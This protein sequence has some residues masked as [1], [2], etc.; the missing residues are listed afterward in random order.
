[1]ETPLKND[2]K[3]NSHRSNHSNH[4]PHLNDSKS[5][6]DKKKIV[7]VTGSSGREELMVKVSQELARRH[8]SKGYFLSLAPGTVASF[9]TSKG[10]D[11]DNVFQLAPLST[12][13]ENPDVDYVRKSE[14]RY[15]F[16]V[17]DIWQLTALRNKS[18]EKIPEKDIFRYMEFII[19]GTEK[20]IQEVKPDCVFMMDIS[21]Y[22]YVLV[23]KIFLAHHIPVLELINPRIPG[24]FT[25]DNAFHSEWPLLVK[26]YA[27]IKE[28]GMTKADQ[29]EAMKLIQS[30]TDAP[31]KPDDSTLVKEPLSVKLSRVKMDL[32]RLAHRRR[33]PHLAPF[34]WHPLKDKLLKRS[35]RFEQPLEHEKYVFFPLQVFPEA[36]TSIR[37][38]WY[39][40][41]VSLIDNL[42]KAIPCDYKLYVKEHPKN[43]SIRPAGF[44]RSIKKH[45][46]VRL[47]SPFANT[48]EMIKK[49]SLVITITGTVGWEAVLLQKPVLT[50]GEVF[51]NLFDEVKRVESIEKLPELVSSSL[52]RTISYDATVKF[53]AAVLKATYLG[54]GAL[55]GDCQHR[56]L[57]DENINKIVTG[58]ELYTEEIMMSRGLKDGLSSGKRSSRKKAQ[59]I[60]L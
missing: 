8:D 49:S 31:F 28:R 41:Q 2:E 19:K 20:I 25:F 6:F 58:L 4:F 59:Q 40:D 15:D 17:F 33:L 47:I 21:G 56:S 24:R 44:H 16:R 42:V 29:E 18:R 9:L 60:P 5:S 39:V 27:S 22:S 34:L 1:M 7:F 10:I 32:Q 13:I 55:P 35:S 30:F 12:T 52:G 36:S 57:T 37:G 38:K 3:N 23:Y 53:V 50:F 51:Y 43:F 54:I 45:Q 46:N 26:H 14:D 48:I 11:K